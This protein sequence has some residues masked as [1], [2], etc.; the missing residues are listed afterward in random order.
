[1]FIQTTNDGFWAVSQLIGAY[2]SGSNVDATF[3]GSNSI[4]LFECDSSDNATATLAELM[5]A[6]G[7]VPITPVS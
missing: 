2:V 3:V 4:T 7:V 5:A 6:L 1:M